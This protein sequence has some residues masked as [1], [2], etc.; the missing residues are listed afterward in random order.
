MYVSYE[1]TL[2]FFPLSLY[3]M[4]SLLIGSTISTLRAHSTLLSSALVSGETNSKV[5][6]ERGRKEGGEEVKGEVEN[7]MLVEGRKYG[8]LKEV[9]KGVIEGKDEEVGIV[10]SNL[11]VGEIID[12]LK[13]RMPERVV[14]KE[15]VVEK[16]VEV[17]IE[18]KEDR[19]GE[20]GGWG[21]DNGMDVTVELLKSVLHQSRESSEAVN[22][23]VRD[24]ENKLQVANVERERLAGLVTAMG[25]EKIMYQGTNIEYRRKVES[26]RGDVK[27]LSEYSRHLEE[28]VR[29]YKVKVR[30]MKGE[31]EGMRVW[32]DEGRKIEGVLGGEDEGGEDGLHGGE[33]VRVRLKRTGTVEVYGDGGFRGDGF[34]DDEEGEEGRG[35]AL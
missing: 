20:R 35:G 3:Y 19:G 34:K 26:L 22:L 23:T 9:L 28:K 8:R 33:R 4:L 1:L 2:I 12:Y 17:E 13:G 32:V 11:R 25:T 27:V 15:V 16:V 24:L 18:R 30:N 29:S 10:E 6:Y 5:S 7:V 21:K 14:E 31:V